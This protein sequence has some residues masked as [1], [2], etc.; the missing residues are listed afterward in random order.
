MPPRDDSWPQRLML[1]MDEQL[2]SAVGSV[3]ALAAG[4]A[5]TPGGWW[6]RRQLERSLDAALR[7]LGLRA[8]LNEGAIVVLDPGFRQR[9]AEARQLWQELHPE[10]PAAG[11]TPTKDL[12]A[13]VEAMRQRLGVIVESLEARPPP[14]KPVACEPDG[15]RPAG[16]SA[17]GYGNPPRVPM[18]AERPVT[19]KPA[20]RLVVAAADQRGVRRAARRR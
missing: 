4:E 14:S 7:T 6:R 10:A 8:V 18:S 20:E 13:G 2:V 16:S 12:L 19:A 5:P 9:A 17:G 11:P 15:L 3:A 1:Q